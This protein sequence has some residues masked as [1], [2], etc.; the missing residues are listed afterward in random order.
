MESVYY[1]SMSSRLGNSK[2]ASQLVVHK[3][4]IAKKNSSFKINW[5]TVIY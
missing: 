1:E 4:L 3:V 5:N 2:K